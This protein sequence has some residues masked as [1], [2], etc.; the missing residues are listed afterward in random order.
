MVVDRKRL[1]AVIFCFGCGWLSL[2]QAA[3]FH[4]KSDPPLIIFIILLP[5]SFVLALLALNF[6]TVHFGG[7]NLLSLHSSI[8]IGTKQVFS[9][10]VHLNRIGS[11][12]IV[13]WIILCTKG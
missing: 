7:S 2:S 11:Q 10:K 9:T 5:S 8:T 6:T 12:E 3:H 1:G 4:E 13:S